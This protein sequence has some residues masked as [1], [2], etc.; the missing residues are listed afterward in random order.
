MSFLSRLLHRKSAPTIPGA[1]W[2]DLPD[3]HEEI[4]ARQRDG[5][6]SGDDA[7]GL[8]HFVEEG[9]VLFSI[10]LSAEDAAAFDGDVERL[11]S[12]RPANVT[13]AYD[14]PPK[15]FRDADPARDRKPK[16]RIQ[17]MHSFSP[18]ARRLYLHPRLAR[19]MELILDEPVVATQSLYFEYGSQQELHRDSIVVPTPLFGHLAAAWIALEDIDPRSGALLYVP[20]SHRLP[21]YEFEPGQYLYDPTRMG[22]VD[23]AA[24]MRF[25]AEQMAA[26]RLEPKMF[27]AKRGQVFIWHSALLHGGGKVEDERL[28]RKSYVVHYSSARTHPTRL[29]A[30]LEPDGQTTIYSTSEVMEKDGAR[31][32]A[33]P[34]DGEAIGTR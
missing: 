21:F 33:N 11:W 34:L 19:W 9:Y 16:Y 5:R 4:D 2:L 22:T 24:A 20:R 27:T 14:T 12:E 17:D 30:V 23:V 1:I 18:T 7:D 6:M 13:M 15:R 3:A 25:H 32:F 26:H 8:H 29:A 10:D 28:T 31:G